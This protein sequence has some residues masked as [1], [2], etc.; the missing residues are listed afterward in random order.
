MKRKLLNSGFSL[1]I[2]SGR[3]SF[4][5]L[6]SVFLS[7]PLY[8]Q[9]LPLGYISYYSQKGN[10]PDLLE[11]LVINQSQGFELSKDRTCTK[12]TP[13]KDDSTLNF[14]PPACRGIIADKIFGEFII[15]FDYKL[16]P[17]SISG[18]SGFYFMAPVKSNYTY[19][20]IAFSDDSLS[21]F[22][23]DEGNVRNLDNSGNLKI[24]TGWNKVR[25]ERNILNRNLLITMNG[26]TSHRVTFTD[27][28][29]V[30]GYVGFGTQD[31]PSFLRNINIWAPT[32]FTDTL[33]VGE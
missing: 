9:Q 18:T 11:S 1:R 7:M 23:V 33:Y 17:I 10:T 22:Y 4:I 24:N 19:Y 15:E 25:I 12:I 5:G 27:R 32:A 6:I 16:Q 13:F 14:L 8:A 31:I 20:A 30:M 2:A 3:I 21:F 29:L 28:D 26:D